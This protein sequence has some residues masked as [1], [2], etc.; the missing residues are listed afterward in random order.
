MTI[1]IIKADYTDARHKEDIPYLLNLYATDPM[2][3]GQPISKETYQ[4][5]VD[6]LAKVP[7]A[8]SVIVYVDNKPAG[9][10]NCF[11]AFSTFACKP[12]VN[13]HDLCIIKEHRGLGLSYKMLDKIEEIA[14]AKGCCKI[15]LE[16]LNNNTIAKS[17]Y[18]KFGF[19]A[20][21]LNSEAGHAVFW[22]KKLIKP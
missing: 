10:A 3:G 7:H 8:F 21:K 18:N 13:I 6:A 16:V 14:L 20:Y 9:L 17:I 11:E 22:E 15:T 2:G 5:L 1:D 19:S 12:I 4:N